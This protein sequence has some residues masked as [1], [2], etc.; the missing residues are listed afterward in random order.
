MRHKFLTGAAVTMLV[1]LAVAGA[2]SAQTAI[3]PG[4]TINGELTGRDA[5]WNGDNTPMDCYVL[6]TAAGQSYVVDYRSN[7]FDAYLAIGPGRTCQGARHSASDDDSGGGLHSRLTLAGDGEVWFIRANAIAE[8]SAGAYTLAVS[9]PSAAAPSRPVGKPPA[10]GSTTPPANNDSYGPADDSI[11]TYLAICMA[12]D[13]VETGQGVPDTE[14]RTADSM[15]IFEFLLAAGEEEGLSEQEITT[16]VTDYVTAWSSSP[17]L[18]RSKPPG[19][20][21]RECI[22]TINSI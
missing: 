15:R 3:R 18:L 20:T 4:Q 22:D 11:F 9:G 2:A 12:A 7:A 13:F 16:I 1:S 6:Q 17:E 8:G 5:R 21:R 19:E 10:G 14:A